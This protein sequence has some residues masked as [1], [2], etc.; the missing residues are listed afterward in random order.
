MGTEN[1]L[2]STAGEFKL[3]GRCDLCRKWRHEVFIEEQSFQVTA[4]G[5]TIIPFG[6]RFH[7]LAAELVFSVPLEIFRP[8]EPYVIMLQFLV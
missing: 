5:G 4:K 6:D 2:L 3:R 1:F 7:V 8:E